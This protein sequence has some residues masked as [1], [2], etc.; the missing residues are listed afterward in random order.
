MLKNAIP[1][2]LSFY[3]GKRI[4]VTGHTG[5]KGSWLTVLLKFLE[6]QTTGY[7]LAPEPG[8][9]YEKI[10]G[11]QWI[12]S[13]IG[14]LLD[15]KK[16][17]QT[18]CEF[19]PEIVF[20]LAAFCFVKEC[21]E[22][23]VKTYQTNVT[24]TLHLLEA[25]RKCSSVKSIL[26]VST[27]KVYRNKGDGAI[28]QENDPIGGQ[29]P[30]SSSKS[31]ME[32]LAQDYR[33]SYFQTQ[34]RCVGLSIARASNVLGGRDQTQSRLIPSILHSLDHHLPV[35]IRHPEQTR[36]WQSVLDALNGYLTIARYTYQ[37]PLLYSDIWNIGPTKDGIRS[38]GWVFQ[39]IQKSFQDLKSTE[40][41]S[42][43]VAESKTLGLDIQ[44]S[45]TNLDWEPQLSCEETIQQVVDF[46]KRQ[47]AG[48]SVDKIC[49]EQV[50]KYFK[51][52]Y[53][54]ISEK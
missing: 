35:S 44:K 17:E 8:S 50:K 9:L 53:E 45:L 48:E 33:R 30:Y 24:G 46:Y 18:I 22:N 37:K 19:Q 20:H 41:T 43:V 26:L 23:P 32:I 1:N 52:N 42:F 47:Q 49:W 16:L 10:N 29:C 3:R 54:T 15:T 25:L 36:P 27:D 6:T 51:K 39:T 31:C 5:F 21:F 14:D 38:V 4:L 40:G 28:Y 12:H 13:V 7:A 2:N 11:D 34:D